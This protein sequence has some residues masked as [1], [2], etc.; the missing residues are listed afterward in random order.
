[1]R[2]YDRLRKSAIK[3]ASEN[4]HDLGLFVK[5]R[6]MHCLVLIPDKLRDELTKYKFGVAKCVKCHGAIWVSSHLDHFDGYALRHKCFP[7]V[8][9]QAFG[10]QTMSIIRAV[11]MVKDKNNDATFKLIL[12][13]K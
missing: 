1:M 2:R 7:R 5:P 13:I 11:K 4:G 6:S 9:I 3:A 12:G 10:V 8:G